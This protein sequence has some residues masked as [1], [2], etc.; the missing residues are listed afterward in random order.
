MWI[1]SYNHNSL[2]S[3]RFRPFVN[4]LAKLGPGFTKLQVMKIAANCRLL[5]G[6]Y[7]SVYGGGFSRLPHSPP[8]I[9][10]FGL[11]SFCDGHAVGWESLG[12][13]RHVEDKVRSDRFS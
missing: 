5:P 8:E 1:Y 10:D 4:A 7:E 6:Q 2:G 13:S 11:V 3:I 9:G 12:R